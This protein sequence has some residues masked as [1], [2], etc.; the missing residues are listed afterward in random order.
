MQ[1][2]ENPCVC[3]AVVLLV[4]PPKTHRRSRD[5]LA[6]LAKFTHFGQLLGGTRLPYK[7]EGKGCWNEGWSV[8]S[9]G[10]LHST[11]HEIPS[12]TLKFSRRTTLNS[13]PLQHLD[14]TRQAA[15]PWDQNSIELDQCKRPSAERAWDQSTRCSWSLTAQLSKKHASEGIHFGCS[16]MPKKGV[17]LLIVT[18]S[19]AADFLMIKQQNPKA[20]LLPPDF[21]DGHN[22]L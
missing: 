13:L 18:L 22:I 1:L 16:P 20:E 8:G 17:R 2:Q 6:L 4:S 12:M 14:A 11:S 19:S 10:Q 15:A 7:A 5:S 3:C 21:R 9:V